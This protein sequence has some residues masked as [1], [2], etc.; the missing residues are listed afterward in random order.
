M[1]IGAVC[2]FQI[3]NG[4]QLKQR[5]L[6]FYVVIVLFGFEISL[7]SQ[8]PNIR[9]SQKIKLIKKT[10]LKNLS[11]LPYIEYIP[12]ISPSESGQILL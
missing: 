5:L 11:F 4:N 12:S 3:D 10:V 8:E 9:L 2:L 7:F 6:Q 1:F